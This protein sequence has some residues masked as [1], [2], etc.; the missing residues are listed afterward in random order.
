[1]TL[2]IAMIQEVTDERFRGRVT[3]VY[4]VLAA[5]AMSVAN[6]AY[7]ALSTWIAPQ[8]LMLVVGIAF[9]VIAGVYYGLSRNRSQSRPLTV[10]GDALEG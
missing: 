5:G 4:F 1:M 7:G 10:V 8:H 9:T 6:W 3:S 2:A